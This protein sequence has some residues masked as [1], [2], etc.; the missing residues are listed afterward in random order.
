MRRVLLLSNAGITTENKYPYQGKFQ[1]CLIPGG[2][3]KI[4]GFTEI[5]TCTALANAL[6]AQPIA[7]A[8]DA[9]NW[10]AYS[11][12]VFNNC[13]KSLNFAGTL[14]GVSAGIWKIKNLWGTKWGE[15]GYIRLAAG[16]TCGL[17][18]MASY[19]NK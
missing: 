10:S 14:V 6:N 7:V 11:S 5:T 19:P 8:V 16:N 18:N 2:N 13:A 4:S 3:F 17:C 9:T 1:S 15:N 12:G